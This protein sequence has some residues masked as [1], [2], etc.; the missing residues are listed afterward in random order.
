MDIGIFVCVREGGIGGGVCVSLVD[1]G[2]V[3]VSLCVIM[4]VYGFV[5]MFVSLFIF[6]PHETHFQ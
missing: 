1:A 6:R 3:F 5:I 4:L 2:F